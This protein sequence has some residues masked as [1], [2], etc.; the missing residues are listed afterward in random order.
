MP[1]DTGQAPKRCLQG[2]GTTRR[3]PS[4][5]DPKK[6]GS[7][8]FLG[9]SVREEHKA[10]KNASREVHDTSSAVVHK[11]FARL[12]TYIAASRQAGHTTS[13]APQTEDGLG[14]RNLMATEL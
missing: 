9:A 12:C 3:A 11:A 2:G 5:P 1:P 10:K 14:P 4:S 8:I 13:T 7:K 6:S